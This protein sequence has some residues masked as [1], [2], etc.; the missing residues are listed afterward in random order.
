M[1][2]TW[3]QSLG[4]EGPLEKEKATPS[5]IQAWRIPWGRKESDTTE[6]LWL[7][8]L[9]LQLFWLLLQSTTAYM[10]YIVKI[11]FSQSWRLGSTSRCQQIPCLMRTCLLLCKWPSSCCVLRG[12]RA[13]KEHDLRSLLM[14]TETPCMKALPSWPKHLPEASL[15]NPITLGA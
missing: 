15:L 5:N 6:R 12:W 13:E 4:W 3:V 1:W 14:R 11:D 7:S 10:V 9:S 2:E 8:H